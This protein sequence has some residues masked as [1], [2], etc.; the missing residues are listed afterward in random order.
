MVYPCCY[1][2]RMPPARSQPSP[3]QDGFAALWHEPA[4]LAA[5]LMWRWC[6]GLAAWGLAIVGTVWFLDS[7]LVSPRDELLLSTLQP[8]LLQDAMQ[9]IFYGSLPRLV[10]QSAAFI[11]GVTLL[12]C[13]A[14]TAGR[15]AILGR[16]VAMFRSD[17][18]SD[19]KPPDLA[20]HFGSILTLQLVRAT[21]LMLARAVLV[22]SVLLASIL[23]VKQHP[24][25][26]SLCLIFG[27]AVASIFGVTVN[28]VFGLAPLFCVRN[29]ASAGE[30]LSQAID[31]S[32]RCAGRLLV[33]GIGFSALRLLWFGIMSFIAMSAVGVVARLGFNWALLTVTI[34]GLT[35]FAGADLLSLAQ[36]A[37]YVSV[38]E[39]DDRPAAPQKVAPPAPAPLLPGA[40]PVLDLQ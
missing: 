40:A 24:L 32:A 6:F 35:Y 13:L 30:A 16:L 39:E 1:P 31:F 10:L 12:W 7:L 2:W 4:L 29:G 3:L 23:A 22:G 8:Q 38:A 5:E 26:A 28:R 11:F 18:D 9:H 17:N 34:L 37:S 27:V 14:S 20:W 21:W 19:G 15:A 25:R 33:P 36:L